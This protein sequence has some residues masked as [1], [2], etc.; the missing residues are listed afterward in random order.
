MLGASLS[1]WFTVINATPASEA[2][3]DDNIIT[4]TITQ[5]HYHS[6]PVLLTRGI[7]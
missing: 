6:D 4:V 2:Y 5:R 1:L 3:R 7:L